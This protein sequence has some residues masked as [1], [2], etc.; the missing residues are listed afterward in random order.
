MKPNKNIPDTSVELYELGLVDAARALQNGEFTSESYVGRLLDRARTHAD[1]KAFITIDET[2]ALEAARLAD[3]LLQKGHHAPL[4]GVPLGVKDSYMTKGLTTT[5]G[6][7]ATRNFKPASDAEVVSRPVPGNTP[8]AQGCGR[9][10]GRS[11]FRQRF[12]RP[13]RACHLVHLFARDETC[14]FRIPGGQ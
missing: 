10:A 8:Q 7:S 1:L 9:P 12:S 14:R 5:F 3:H 4:L 13:G 6:T 11:G 2:S